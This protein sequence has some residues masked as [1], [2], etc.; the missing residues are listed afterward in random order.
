MVLHRRPG[1]S[2]ALTILTDSKRRDAATVSLFGL[3]LLSSLFGYPKFPWINTSVYNLSYPLVLLLVLVVI[4]FE[5]SKEIFGRHR[6]TIYLAVTFYGWS[7]V[8]A[9]FSDMQRVAIWY[10][11]RYSIYLFLFLAL[12][13]ITARADLR[14]PLLRLVLR[15][16]IIIGA[17]GILEYLG[18]GRWIF[19]WMRSPDSL[20]G[21]RIASLLQGPNEF[22]TLMAIGA[23]LALL[24]RRANSI[25]PLESYLSLPLF[26]AMVSLS[27]SR[28]G[29]LLFLLGIFLG[30][31]YRV[32]NIKWVIGIF[33][34][35]LACVTL[36][37]LTPKQSEI[38]PSSR[39]PFRA[40]TLQAKPASEPSI[41]T[42]P[43]RPSLWTRVTGALRA[44]ARQVQQDMASR[45]LLWR[46]AF[47]EITARPV[48]GIGLNV[49]SKQVGKRV[50]GGEHVYA[51][52]VFLSVS[53]EM[54][55]PGLLLFLAVLFSVFRS[56]P[57]R[58]PM[59]AIPV[60]LVGFS[61]V[62]DYY[63]H[64]PTFATLALFFV[65]QAA[66]SKDENH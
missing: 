33:A 54:G 61:Q 18:T 56:G 17:F 42:M 24:L 25:S 8:S 45:F 36:L 2:K 40:P 21:S 46:A 23:V 47:D 28:N 31:I 39:Y 16:L 22:S 64:D 10:S 59:V 34:V 48:T 15:F 58:K 51:H 32:L 3:L 5:K 11:L 63:L 41:T 9:L 49:F 27:A 26:I 62:L 4:N 1:Y 50:L 12:L 38:R 19:T 29:A 52:N 14:S 35:W 66:N 13:P 44:T 7:W 60:L 6:L 65:A 55:L 53:A 20:G 30:W 37:P 57:L 43:A